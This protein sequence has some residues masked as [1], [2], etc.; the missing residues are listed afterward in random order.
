MKQTIRLTESELRSV[1]QDSVNEAL[2]D[3]G[4]LQ[5]VGRGMRNAFAGDGQRVNQAANSVKNGIP[6]L[7]RGIKNSG[8]ALGNNINKRYQAAKAGYQTGQN[9]DQLD[10]LS[11]LLTDLQN[12]GVLHGNATNKAVQTLMSQIGKLRGGNNSKNNAWYN[13]VAGKYDE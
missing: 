11:K 12:S 4:F 10:K 7:G 9:N 8:Q 5:N 1:I 2:Q 3:E 13:S 6:K